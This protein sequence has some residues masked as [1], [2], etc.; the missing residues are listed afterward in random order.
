M[1]MHEDQADVDADLVHRLLADQSPHL[2]TLPIT[3]IESTGTVNALFRV[4]EELIARLPLVAKWRDA[5]EREWEWLP[6]FSRRLVPL[7]LP[8]PILHGRPAEYST[9]PW[10]AS[11]TT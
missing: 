1:K 4:G 10:T 6:W 2:S 3:A 11:P 7:R 9:M 5:T 8:E